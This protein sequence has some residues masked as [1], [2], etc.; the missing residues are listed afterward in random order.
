MW[1]RLFRCKQNLQNRFFQQQAAENPAVFKQIFSF[2][3]L[4]LQFRSW[5]HVNVINREQM[6]VTFT[7]KFCSF[8]MHFWELLLKATAHRYGSY[9][10]KN[11]ASWT[12]NDWNTEHSFLHPRYDPVGLCRIEIFVNQSPAAARVKLIKQILHYQTRFRW[13]SSLVGQRSVLK[14]PL[15]PEC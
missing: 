4:I 8:V 12:S 14:A 3:C 2:S 1:N 7:P 5:F 13:F 10:D 9:A 6:W 11:D 15:C